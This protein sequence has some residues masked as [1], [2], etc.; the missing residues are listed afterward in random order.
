MGGIIQY[1]SEKGLV[2]SLCRPHGDIPGMLLILQ[3][4]GGAACLEERPSGAWGAGF[5]GMFWE[6]IGAA[7]RTFVLTLAALASSGYFNLLFSCSTQD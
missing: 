7:I 3:E 2:F 5:L 1:H 4:R 6:D